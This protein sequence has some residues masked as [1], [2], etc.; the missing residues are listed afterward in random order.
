LRGSE[1]S[2]GVLR[3]SKEHRQT[4]QQDHILAL[5]LAN[6]K[7]APA[8]IE[9]A[10]YSSI[11]SKEMF[12][13]VPS[14]CPVTSGGISMIKVPLI[15]TADPKAI[16]TVFKSIVEPLEV[17]QYILERNRKHFSQARDTPLATAAI[18]NLIGFGGTTLVADK[19]LK[20]TEIIRTITTNPS[21]RAIL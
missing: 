3:S 19:L 1:T 11:A 15:P 9:K 12:R 17:E 18:T 6:P 16:D 20:G 2:T 7:K 13:R 5:K 21:G 10:F 4:Y 8:I 14:P